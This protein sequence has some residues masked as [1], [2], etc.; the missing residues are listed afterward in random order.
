MCR[1]AECNKMWPCRATNGEN[2]MEV[3]AACLGRASACGSM[4]IRSSKCRP[5]QR[6]AAPH[7]MSKGF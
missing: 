2:N 1:V 4:K 7:M 5:H 3:N 6:F